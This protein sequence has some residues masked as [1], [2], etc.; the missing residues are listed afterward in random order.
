M[1]VRKGESDL[2]AVECYVVLREVAHAAHVLE[3]LTAVDIVHHK[4]DSEFALKHIVHRDNERMVY[5]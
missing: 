5:L 1:Q 4:V 3:Q 2:T